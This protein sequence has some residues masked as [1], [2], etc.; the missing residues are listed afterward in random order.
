MTYIAPQS[1][2]MQHIDRLVQIRQGARPAPVNVEIDLSN[3]CSLGCEWC[4]FAYTHTRGPLKGKRA[5]P[6]GAVPG[7]DLMDTGLALRIVDELAQAGV[8]SIVW[9]GGGEPT[10]HPDFDLIVSHAA[11]IGV[12]QGIY[13][14]GTLISDERA[15]LLKESMAWV[16]VS[17][18]AAD[19][20][21]YKKLKGVD[22]FEAALA[23]VDRLV[24]AP[25]E[26]VIG[27]GF[28]VCRENA[29]QIGGARYLANAHGADYVQYRPTILFDG[30]DQSR[31]ADDTD[32]LDEALEELARFAQQPDVEV[33]LD[34]FRMYRDWDG[35]PY[36]TCFWTQLQSVV[37][38]NGK[39]WRCV[40]KREHAAAELGD[41]SV[42][43]FAEI[44]SRS[45]A[46]QVDGD[47]RVMCRGHLPNLALNEIMADRPHEAFI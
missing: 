15:E 41:L 17:L 19:R 21:T 25:G 9:T 8:R 40:N 10:L 6:A 18:D 42:E 32:W 27:L 36:P 26:A 43:S 3:R 16:Y 2:L 22:R 33:D 38:P 28:L 1:K 39:V 34:R 23:G 5:K 11:A 31:K 44:W 12:E 7:G 35:H 24:A 20:E 47:C 37:T 46:A 30:G 14:N 4:H 29:D 13:T 45:S